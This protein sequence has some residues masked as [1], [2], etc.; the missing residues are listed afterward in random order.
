MFD[1]RTYDFQFEL[2]KENKIY[3][4]KSLDISHRDIQIT[5]DKTN[6][7]AYDPIR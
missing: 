1:E 6:Q 7:N 5:E 2:D 3:K 4:N